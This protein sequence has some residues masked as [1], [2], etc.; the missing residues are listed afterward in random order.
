MV[1]EMGDREK[2][3]EREGVLLRSLRM[4]VA[5]ERKKSSGGR[6]VDSFAGLWIARLL[7]KGTTADRLALQWTGWFRW[8]V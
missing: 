5:V 1:R 4:G 8:L 2:E 7:R 3:K 6:D